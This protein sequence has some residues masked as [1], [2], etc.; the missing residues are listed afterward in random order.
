MILL[1]SENELKMAGERRD[2]DEGEESLHLFHRKRRAD[3][4]PDGSGFA[5]DLPWEVANF[6]NY[7]LPYYH[8][9]IIITILLLISQIV[10][11]DYP[12]TTTCGWWY[13]R[14]MMESER[15]KNMELQWEKK[16]DL[17]RFN[18]VLRCKMGK[19]GDLTSKDVDFGDENSGFMVV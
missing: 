17:R 4:C 10:S 5:Q 16:G 1:A 6:G 15:H 7:D 14:C 2:A 3:P 18:G 11:E 8:Y 12:P 9:Y 19:T 13:G